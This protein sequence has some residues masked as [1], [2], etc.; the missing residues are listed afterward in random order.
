MGVGDAGIGGVGAHQAAAAKPFT[1]LR[2]RPWQ[3]SHT[4]GELGRVKCSWA[5]RRSG[6]RQERGGNGQVG[7]AAGQM[8]SKGW[9]EVCFFFVFSIFL[10]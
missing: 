6:P 4:R 2:W 9:E 5:A 10:F 1:H 8:A 3:P 7:R